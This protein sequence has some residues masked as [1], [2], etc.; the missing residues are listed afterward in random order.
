MVRP[1]IGMGSL[2]DHKGFGALHPKF[3][4]ART[5]TDFTLQSLSRVEG[6][7]AVLYS[8]DHYPTCLCS[9]GLK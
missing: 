5:A 1:N 8:A 7:N 6:I 4:R 9:Q 3:W 2:E